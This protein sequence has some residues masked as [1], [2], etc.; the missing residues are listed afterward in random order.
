MR[1]CLSVGLGLV[2]ATTAAGL[3]ASSAQA[4]PYVVDVPASTRLP[5]KATSHAAREVLLK[6]GSVPA[7][8][9]LQAAPAKR[10]GALTVHRFEQWHQGLRVMHRGGAVVVDRSGR[11]SLAT[12]RI[13][14]RLPASTTPSLSAAQAAEVASKRAGV[15]ATAQQATLVV[16]PTPAGGALAWAVVP[17]S[18]LPIPYAPLVVLDAVSGDVLSVQNLV[19]FKNKAKV[20]PFNPVKTPNQIEVT[21]PVSD[22]LTVPQ[23]ELV[24]SYNCVDRKRVQHVSFMG[25]SADVHVCDLEQAE[26][27]TADGDFL[28]H[29][30]VDD[31]S[32]GDA[33]SE[34]SIFYHANKA[35]EFFRQFDPSFELQASAKPL[36]AVANLM[37]PAGLTDFDL[38]AMADP[39]LPLEPF[40]N[41]FYT[42]WDPQ[43][44]P[45]MSL[46]FPQVTGASL[47]FGQ[48]PAADYAL[49]GDVVYHEFGHAVVDSTARLVGSWHLDEQGASASPGA[50]NEA[51]ADYFSSAITG[52]PDQGEYAAKDF[53]A[54]AIRHLTNDNTCPADL[55]G[56]VHADSEF[57]SA[58]LWHAR[59]QV[60]QKP[61]FDGAVFA[62][63]QATSTGDLGYE[64][65]AEALVQTVRASVD[66]AAGDALQQA[67]TDRGVLPACKR[68]LTW[69]GKP[70]LS[71]DPNL[72]GAF[73]SA[74]K[75][76]M[77]ASMTYAPG[78]FQV[79]VPLPEKSTKIKVSFA[80][81]QTSSSMGIPGFGSPFTP[82]LLVNFTE[83]IA[84]A[85][86]THNAGTPV[87]VT[88]QS[89]QCAAEI[90]VPDAAEHAYVM[91]VNKGDSDGY[92]RSLKFEIEADDVP[93]DG[94]V[95]DAS[96]EDASPDAGSDSSASE[97]DATDPA[98]AEPS[99]DDA[100]QT[101]TPAT[102]PEEDDGCGC[103]MV[104][105]S[106]ARAGLIAAVIG[107]AGMV[108]ARRRRR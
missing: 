56:E 72:A 45:V 107:L 75:S 13:E 80:K 106:G 95:G 36:F 48:G 86:I 81:L 90:E 5:A 1:R 42:G 35:Y 89:N 8:V 98:D 69:E 87:T 28:H 63:L 85:G 4:A 22:G 94:G 92:F 59:S 23:N 41:A 25:M 105:A 31:T 52:D 101:E 93:P 83:P 26:A 34:L 65:L 37:L 104:G 66:E 74:G 33:F 14:Q 38:T 24:E 2:L 77:P 102:T 20:F 51:L 11:V 60:A 55:T 3:D 40:S 18:L 58:A 46:L 53:G 30:Y 97:P 67:F 71:S 44:S 76:M 61:E 91:L 39:D 54:D 47:F 68:M 82:A 9:N 10:I 19:R 27:D 15:P 29:A 50:M 108:V 73:V 7:S 12:A 70:L 57:F 6:H 79:D 16:W 100:G 96:D 62:A 64:E 88:C 32:G 84:F 103:T 17:Y 49:D 21:L 43:L 99:G 78:V